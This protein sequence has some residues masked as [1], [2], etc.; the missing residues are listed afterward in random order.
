[1]TNHARHTSKQGI[2]VQVENVGEHGQLENIKTAFACLV[3][4]DK[5]LPND[6]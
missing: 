2:G 5:L 6:P 1:M 3:L 4:R